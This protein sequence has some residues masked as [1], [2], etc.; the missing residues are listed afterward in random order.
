MTLKRKEA[1]QTG[2]KKNCG[3]AHEYVFFCLIFLH[4][5]LAENA[6]KWT[7]PVCPVTGTS[8]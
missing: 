5:F 1:L 4:L 3:S 2:K 6:D 7:I 8:V